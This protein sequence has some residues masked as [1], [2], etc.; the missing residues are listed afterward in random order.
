MRRV[1][2]HFFRGGLVSNLI[3]RCNRLREVDSECERFAS[4]LQSSATGRPRSRWTV[5][6]SPL[7]GVHFSPAPW[8][9]PQ[10]SQPH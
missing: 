4:Q 3:S 5:G 1:K 8:E 2:S 7:L 9:R 10:A 6:W